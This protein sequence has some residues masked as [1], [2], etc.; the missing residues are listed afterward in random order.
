MNTK[1]IGNIGESK[2]LSKFIELGVE[3][4][5]PFGDN[6]KADLV[7]NFNGQ[8]QRV[9]VKTCLNIN[10]RTGTYIINLT[11]SHAHTSKHNKEKY[12]KKDIDYFAVYCIQRKEPLLF[13]VE[14]VLG[15]SS[16]TIRF[17]SQKNAGGSSMPIFEEDNIFEKK[18]VNAESFNKEIVDKINNK[19][20]HCLDC[21]TEISFNA[22]RCV[23]CEGKNRKKRNEENFPF[24]REELKDKIR[25]N[26]F[27]A[28][29]RE[30]KVSDNA[31]RK[32]CIH[33][34]LPFTKR[35][36]NSYSDE[37]WENI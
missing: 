28:I 18:I 5:I 11:N 4:F 14:D 15:K 36:I 25:K 9:Q 22:T 20:N 12:T 32:W 31:V 2:V 1:D 21:G 23:E 33:F 8:L 27:S 30:L 16:I 10:E 26:S 29:G 24:T 6:S 37:E 13:S 7:A 34:N 19:K 3:V 35:D 17:K